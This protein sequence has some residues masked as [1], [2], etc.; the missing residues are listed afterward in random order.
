M[1]RRGE[2]MYL[3]V[4]MPFVQTRLSLRSRYIVHIVSPVMCG[5]IIVFFSFCKTGL[6]GHGRSLC[7]CGA[8]DQQLTVLYFVGSLYT[9][10]DNF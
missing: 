4:C 5:C 6:S 9:V 7:Q 10:H 1:N 2:Q 3:G 8:G